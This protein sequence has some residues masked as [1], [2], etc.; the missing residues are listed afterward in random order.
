MALKRIRQLWLVLVIGVLGLAIWGGVASPVPVAADGGIEN[1]N[2][3]PTPR[4]QSDLNGQANGQSNGQ[5]GSDSSPDPIVNTPPVYFDLPDFRS[6]A[7]VNTPRSI[8]ANSGPT[9][10]TDRGAKEFCANRGL[11]EQ[12]CNPSQELLPEDRVTYPPGIR[13]AE[14]RAEYRYKLSRVQRFDP[15]D[16][17]YPDSR[18]VLDTGE[19]GSSERYLCEEKVG[20]A[21][22]VIVAFVSGVGG[23]NCANAW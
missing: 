20:H 17:P 10:Y 7:T 14:E 2:T 9:T 16:N 19:V 22:Y 18:R 4:G 23:D 12:R 1:L 6:F 3:A 21:T 5:G 15:A 11:D 13:T 8:G